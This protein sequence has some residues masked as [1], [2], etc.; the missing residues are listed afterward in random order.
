MIRWMQDEFASCVRAAQR[1]GWPTPGRRDVVIPREMW[2][3]FW[4]DMDAYLIVKRILKGDY[5]EARPQPPHVP[6]KAQ[7]Q[8]EEQ[9]PANVV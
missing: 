9:T 5:R 6:K 4:R 3:E 7:V 1:E 2:R 8:H